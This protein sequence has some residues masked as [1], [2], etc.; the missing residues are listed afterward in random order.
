MPPTPTPVASATLSTT[1][2]ISASAGISA[3]ADYL[4]QAPVLLAPVPD[5][6]LESGVDFQWQWGGQPL[7]E[8]LAFDLLIWSETED[9]EHQGMEAYGV[10]ETNLSRERK[11]DLDFVETIA[12]HGGGVY[13]WTVI[14]VREEPYERV[15]VWGEKRSFTYVGS[16]VPPEATTEKP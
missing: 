12:E 5:A 8:G 16:P 2:P 9:Q 6:Q 14:V 11:V 3:T 1:V 10:V 13:Y 15:G 7:P 4:F